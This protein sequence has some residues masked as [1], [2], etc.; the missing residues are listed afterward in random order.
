MPSRFSWNAFDDKTVVA[1]AAALQFDGRGA[2]ARAWLAK[3]RPDD[4]FVKETKGVLERHWLPKYAGTKN[5]VERLLDEGIGPMGRLD[6]TKLV[7]YIAKCRNTSTVRRLLREALLR[8]GDADPE[9]PEDAGELA[10]GFVP[11]FAL[12]KPSD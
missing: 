11:R 6:E 9:S 10:A 5:I 2:D 4:D 12:L 1:L 3:Q 8:F 7:E